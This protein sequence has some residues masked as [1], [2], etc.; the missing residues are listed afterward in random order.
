MTGV[1]RFASTHDGL[2]QIAVALLAIASYEAV[3]MLMTPNW[4]LALAN[5][6]E[7]LSLERALHLD[8]EQGIQRTFLE[9]PDLVRTMN[10]FYFFGHF[11]I[12]G[13]FLVWLYHRS[14]PGFGTFRNGFIVASAIAVVIHWRYPTAPPRL[15]EV[16][17]VDTL[18]QLSGIDIGSP[19]SYSFSNPVAAVPS[20]HAGFALGV[21]IG[22]F[23]YARRV[24][25]KV[26]ALLYPALV[27][28][29]TIVTGNH[30]VLDALAGMLVLSLGFAIAWLLFDR[31][32]GKLELA[33]RGG[34]VR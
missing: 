22:V 18:R 10:V 24:V 2:T 27:V 33:T 19:S 17:L 3:R 4:P 34:A 12:T 11:V 14:R 9:V 30:F 21:G 25:W 20:L 7:V 15:A 1:R 32:G 6:R 23:L 31:E 5:A 16:G 29:T 13:V 28:L 8:W 26:A